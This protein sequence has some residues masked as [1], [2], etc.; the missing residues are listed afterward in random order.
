MYQSAVVGRRSVGAAI[1]EGWRLTRAHLGSLI[2]FWLLLLLLNVVLNALVQAIL[3]PLTVPS[4]ADWTGVMERF[5]QGGALD[6]PPL[7]MGWLIVSGLVSLLLSLLV[8]SFTL[9]FHYTLYA[10]VYRRLTGEAPPVVSARPMAPPPAPPVPVEP[11]LPA[12]IVL[13][14]P[15]AEEDE[16]PRVG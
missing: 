5:L 8:T 1:A 13:E 4:V 10:E 2:I 3:L 9:T 11:P 16:G 6:L 12:V 15:P 7:R 14:E